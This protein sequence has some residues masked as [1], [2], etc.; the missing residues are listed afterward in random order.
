MCF[1]KASYQIWLKR[2]PYYETVLWHSTCKIATLINKC[3]WHN[4]FLYPINC[5]GFQFCFYRFFSFV[6]LQ[7]VD[8]SMHFSTRAK[9]CNGIAAKLF[10]GR[11]RECKRFSCYKTRDLIP[12][13]WKEL[14][15][16]LLTHGLLVFDP[17]V[18]EEARHQ[19]LNSYVSSQLSMCNL[20]ITQKLLNG[21]TN[22]YIFENVHEK[23]YAHKCVGQTFFYLLTT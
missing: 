16:D 14:I 23:A 2:N 22:V 3:Y 20:D 7:N 12:P 8:W 13:V 9:I 11:E 17:W 19:T 5:C 18:H 10:E 15:S 4:W 6:W 1:S 21:N